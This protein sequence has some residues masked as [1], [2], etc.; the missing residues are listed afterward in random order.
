MEKRIEVCRNCGHTTDA[1]P[2]LVY[3]TIRGRKEMIGTAVCD[4]FRGKENAIIT[5]AE[6]ES[7]P[8]DDGGE[9]MKCVD[10][11]QPN[12]ET[13]TSGGTCRPRMAE[14]RDAPTPPAQKED[15]TN[16]EQSV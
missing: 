1:G 14:T 3:C 5:P 13:R 7:R 6:D 2:G 8:S 4:E 12:C 15:L 10:C 16:E 11:C 9:E